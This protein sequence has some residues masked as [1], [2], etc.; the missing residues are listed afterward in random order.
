MKNI[1]G[2]VFLATCATSQAA[3]VATDFGGVFNPGFTPGTPSAVDVGDSPVVIGSDL[4]ATFNDGLAIQGSANGG[5]YNN[6]FGPG[7]PAN[8]GNNAAFF[9]LMNG[10]AA[11]QFTSIP[12]NPELFVDNLDVASVTFNQAVSNVSFS[13]QILGNGNSSAVDLL[14]LNGDVLGSVAL[15]ELDTDRNSIA[16]FSDLSVDTSSFGEVFGIQFNNAGPN[17]NPPYGIVV[18][19]FSATAVPEPSSALLAGLTL[20]FPLLRRRR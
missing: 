10:G 13:F 12:N 16:A 17:M 14:A 4:T 7:N 8:T 9:I 19:S 6:F 1:I 20:V 15:T 2:T 11:T 5:L 3:S 18:D